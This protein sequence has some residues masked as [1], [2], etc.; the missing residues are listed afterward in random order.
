MVVIDSVSRQKGGMIMVKKMTMACI[1]ALLFPYIITL[2]W[3]GKIEVKKNFPMETSGKTIILDRKGASSSM[4]VEEYLPGVVAKQMPAD[5]GEEALR[6]Q[7]IIAR[8]YIYGKMN[9]KNEINESELHMEYLEKKQMERLWGSESFVAS[10]ALIE[11]AVRS[12][13]KMAMTYNGTL[14]DPLF[15]RASTGMTRAGD[16]NHPY[17]QPVDAKRDVEAD[18]YLSVTELSKEDFVGKINQ[19]SGDVPIKPDQVPGTIQIISRDQGGYVGQIQIGTKTYSGEDIQRALQLP[20]TSFSFEEY[21]GGIRIV[22]QGIGHGYGMSQFGAKC[23]AEEGWAAEKI[24]SY[25]Y[26]N[27]VI[28]PV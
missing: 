27:I 7:A 20:S 4:D 19:I 23:K 24:L 10:Y 17:L 18:G 25:F 28:N 3:T 6:A 16:N 21:E 22:C 13:S 8:T 5:F 12:T 15:H 26:K 11:N 9:G 1:I 14:I 2:A